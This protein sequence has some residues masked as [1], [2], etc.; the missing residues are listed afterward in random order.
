[1]KDLYDVTLLDRYRLG[2]IL[3]RGGMGTV[4]RAHDTV[5]N[6]DV[7]VK[8]LSATGLGTEG[9]ARML[10]EAQSAAGLNHPNIV[11]VHDAGVVARGQRALGCPTGRCS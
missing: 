10:R 9:K 4:Y 8:L 1:M 7:A 11:A 6:R 5:L 3:G 2:E